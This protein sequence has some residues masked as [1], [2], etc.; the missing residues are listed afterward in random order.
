MCFL[1]SIQVNL[2][3]IIWVVPPMMSRPIFM[4]RSKKYRLGWHLIFHSR[5]TWR[6]LW[7]PFCWEITVGGSHKDRNTIVCMCLYVFT[8]IC[9]SVW[10][11][12]AA[13]STGCLLVQCQTCPSVTSLAAPHVSP[14][15]QLWRTFHLSPCL[16]PKPPPLLLR[17]CALD[18]FF[19]ISFF[20][21]AP[22]P[23]L[24]S[25]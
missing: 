11:V 16:P 25:E 21:P 2:D 14:T 8:C 24:N 1:S 13:R 7:F 5:L 22:C 9:A 18:F 20:P 17:P 4:I 23:C 3:D 6:H 19:S 12:C 10:C 15:L